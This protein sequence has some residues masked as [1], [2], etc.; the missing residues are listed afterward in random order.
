MIT[1]SGAAHRL[2]CPKSDCQFSIEQGSV[3]AI[4]SADSFKK[5]Q[6][7]VNA[8]EISRSPNKKFCPHPGCDSI[9]EGEKSTTRTECP[10]C[11]QP[12]CYSCQTPWHQGKS[13]SQAQREAYK[14]W[15]FNI[16]AHSCPNCK[17]PVE[18]NMGCNHMNC[19]QCQYSWCWVCGHA[20]GHW[21]HNLAAISPFSCKLAPNSFGEWILF[22]LGFI[23]GFAIIPL[24]IFFGIIFGATVQIVKLCCGNCL[25]FRRAR[26]QG[27]CCLIC[28]LALV[29]IFFLLVLAIG[30]PIGA[31]ALGV[32]I[33]PAYLFHLYYFIRTIYWW[34]K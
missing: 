10:G 5:F 14:G 25:S 22:T 7:F 9:I 28:Y 32:F 31:I 33:V 1:Q 2:K 23:V 21:T 24:L 30:A 29:P 18:K 4:V 27:A 11:H 12:V 3:E 16:G 20:I 15:A 13:C 34:C 19:S 17:V 26:R 6:R 8:Y